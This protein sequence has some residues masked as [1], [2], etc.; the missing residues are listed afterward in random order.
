MSTEIKKLHVDRIEEGT[1]IAFSSDGEE[2]TM[3]EKIADIK[4][5]DIINATI[6]ENGEVVSVEVL[7]EE[8]ENKK[9]EMKTRLR[10]LFTK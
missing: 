7:S 6:N 2:Y 5:S 8:T 9:S 3:C 10:N 1:V 4:E